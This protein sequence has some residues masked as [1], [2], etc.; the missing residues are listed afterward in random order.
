MHDRLGA[1]FG[2]DE[3]GAVGVMEHPEPPMPATLIP[4]SSEA[5]AVPARSRAL[6]RLVC[7]AKGS[8]LASRMLTSATR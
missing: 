8:R 4:V 7:V 6:I 5:N 2:G 3:D 1:V